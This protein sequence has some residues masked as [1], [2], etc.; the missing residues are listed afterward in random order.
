MGSKNAFKTILILFLIAL[1]AGSAAGEAYISNEG[2]IIKKDKLAEN[3]LPQPTKQL[4]GQMPESIFEFPAEENIIDKTAEYPELEVQE[5]IKEASTISPSR[6]IIPHARAGKSGIT[7][8][9]ALV[10]DENTITPTGFAANIK[11]CS[12]EPTGTTCED[13]KNN[14]NE[15]ESIGSYQTVWV[16]QENHFIAHYTSPTYDYY[17]RMDATDPLGND[18]CWGAG[19]NDYVQFNHTNTVNP[20]PLYVCTKNGLGF[21]NEQGLWTIDFILHD[22]INSTEDTYY[23][24]IYVDM[25][26]GAVIFPDTA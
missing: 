24:D 19:C 16:Y 7:Y 5:I 18:T 14:C 17:I 23:K 8:S 2:P 10:S 4:F 9:K 25:S 11:T 20:V 15:I 1:L 22:N 3:I 26:T 6:E 13:W 21:Y 12:N